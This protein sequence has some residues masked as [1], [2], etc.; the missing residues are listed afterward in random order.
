M[1]LKVFNKVPSNLRCKALTITFRVPTCVQRV[2]FKQQN[3]T[4]ENINWGKVKDAST[5][6]NYVGNYLGAKGSKAPAPTPSI[7]PLKM[8]NGCAEFNA[9]KRK[10]IWQLKN[11]KGQMTKTLDVSLTYVKDVPIDELQ[12]K[13]LGPFNVE[14]DIPN[15]TAST[16]KITKMDI[17]VSN[18]YLF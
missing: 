7:D 14:F 9:G 18:D 1:N 3:I 8:E 13:Q 6:A 17:K 15:H 11:V 12:F 4:H 10:I 5:L 2:Y 16:I